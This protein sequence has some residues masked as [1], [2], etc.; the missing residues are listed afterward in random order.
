VDFDEGILAFMWDK[1]K[2]SPSMIKGTKF[3]GLVLASLRRS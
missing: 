3:Y 1:K 2:E